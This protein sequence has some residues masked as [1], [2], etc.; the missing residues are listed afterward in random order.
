MKKKSKQAP[1]PG[2]DGGTMSL[3]GHLKELRNRLAV[4]LLLL[5]AMFLLCLGNAQR[6]VELFTQMGAA[7]G[8]QFV[9]ISPQELLMEYFSV[10]LVI[11]LVVC[12]PVIAWQ[13]WRFVQPGL[14]KNENRAFALSLV[15]GMIF[16]CLGVAFAYKIS[17]PFILYFLIHVGDG[18]QIT[19]AVSVQ[20]YISFLMT[21][22]LVFGCVFELPVI[23][24]VLTWLGVIRAGWLKKAQKPAIVLIFVLAALITPPDIVSQV[25]VALPMIALFQLGILLSTLCE[26]SKKRS[27]L[28]D[29]E[30]ATEGAVALK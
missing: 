14:T 6:L 17:M 1:A 15:F 30:T 21:V 23:S 25:M 27:A 28:E 8:Y 19:A 2:E 29:E 20:N 11:A 16:F 4:V 24:V 10:S 22:F 13:V 9:Y 18:S 5:V 3:T 26:K 7:Y 12:L